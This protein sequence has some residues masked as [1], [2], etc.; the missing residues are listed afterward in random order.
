MG[1]GIT[2]KLARS[3]A[4]KNLQP[5][6]PV[7]TDDAT[8]SSGAT[9]SVEPDID[10]APLQHEAARSV[11]QRALNKLESEFRLAVADPPADMDAAVEEEKRAFARLPWAGR[12]AVL[13]ERP[14]K[15]KS[16]IPACPVCGRKRSRM[17]FSSVGG[18]LMSRCLRCDLLTIVN[19]LEEQYPLAHAE[20]LRYSMK[21]FW[22]HLRGQLK[23]LGHRGPVG[24]SGPAE[25]SD[26]VAQ[27][28]RNLALIV[29]LEDLERYTDPGQCPAILLFHTLECVPD[30]ENLLA[31]CYRMLAE[32]GRLFVAA[33]DAKSIQCLLRPSKWNGLQ[34]K[35]QLFCYSSGTLSRLFRAAGFRVSRRLRSGLEV[36]G[37]SLEDAFA[38]SSNE[39]FGFKGFLKRWFQVISWLAN[40]FRSCGSVLYLEAVPNK[41]R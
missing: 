33:S 18:R 10:P 23:E 12:D 32:D 13:E 11:D 19:P 16:G 27:A 24:Y 7:V 3:Y 38:A 34:L 2:M 25:Y 22:F 37:M 1:L 17:R 41:S 39:E 30:P 20:H 8:E 28:A 35:A 4:W 31:K 36:L 21:T 5:I 40:D 26:A 9:D 14:R 15:R 29:P 6:D